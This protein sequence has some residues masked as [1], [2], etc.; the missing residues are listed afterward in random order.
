MTGI[1][2]LMKKAAARHPCRDRPLFG[3][4]SEEVRKT[5]EAGF[6][7]LMLEGLAGV[8]MRKEDADRVERRDRVE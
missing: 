5:K 3:V 4:G 7:L 2:R 6:W 8:R 1:K